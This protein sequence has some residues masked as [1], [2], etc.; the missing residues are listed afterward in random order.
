MKMMMSKRLLAKVALTGV[1]AALAD[2]YKRQPEGL[3]GLRGISAPPLDFL[4]NSFLCDLP[5]PSGL[6]GDHRASSSVG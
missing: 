6:A 2:V 3:Q 4:Y 1:G 5:G